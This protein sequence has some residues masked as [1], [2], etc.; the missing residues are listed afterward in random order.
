MWRPNP[1][2][3]ADLLPEKHSDLFLHDDSTDFLWKLVPAESADS[4]F[5]LHELRTLG[6]L[7]Q[8]RFLS[9]LNSLS[10]T[11]CGDNKPNQRTQNQRNEE[12][13]SST[14][15]FVAC[16][17]TYENRKNNPK[18]E[19][20]RRSTSHLLSRLAYCLGPKA[21]AMCA[22]K[23][24]D[25]PIRGSNSLSVNLCVF[26][27]VKTTISRPPIPPGLSLPAI[28]TL[29]VA[30]GNSSSIVGN[31]LPFGKYISA[32]KLAPFRKS[33]A[34]TLSW[35]QLTRGVSET[36]ANQSLSPFSVL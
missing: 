21:L 22:S 24:F 17:N 26:D 13:A 15:A 35:M 36:T 28:K 32:K 2:R 33:P 9:D 6:T 34:I 29:L 19:Y 7:L 3:S 23:A 11:H 10:G 1:Y 8:P 25:A 30:N 31:G 12:K 5:L 4:R 18:N 16:V 14:T 27:P 20:S